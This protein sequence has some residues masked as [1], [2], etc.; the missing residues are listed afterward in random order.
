[1]RLCDD[2]PY[3]GAG[4]SPRDCDIGPPPGGA[5]PMPLASSCAAGG[6]PGL[7]IFGEGDLRFTGD[8]RAG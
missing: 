7:P 2:G 6:G 4:T 8:A 3:D 5:G 1:M